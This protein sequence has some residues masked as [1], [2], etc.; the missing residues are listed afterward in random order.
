VAAFGHQLDVAGNRGVGGPGVAPAVVEVEFIF[1]WD[2]LLVDEDLLADGHGV[3]LLKSLVSHT[4][5]ICE[6]YS[7]LLV[8][9]QK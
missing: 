6:D 1:E 8:R 2:A 5:A 3:D 7:A 9:A 4:V